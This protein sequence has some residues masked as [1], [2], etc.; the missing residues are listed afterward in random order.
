MTT[1][2]TSPKPQRAPAREPAPTTKASPGGGAR[3][4]LGGK[5]FAEQEALLA[6]AGA[7]EAPGA[8]KAARAAPTREAEDH[9]GGCC[10]IGREKWSEA[11]AKRAWDQTSAKSVSAVDVHAKGTKKDGKEGPDNYVKGRLSPE[12]I[13]SLEA[14][15]AAASA[16]GVHIHCSGPQST[17]RD[18]EGQWKMFHEK[19]HD[20]S[21]AARPGTSNHGT[22]RAID[23]ANSG[24]GWLQANAGHFGFVNYPNENWHFDHVTTPKVVEKYKNK[25][26]DKVKRKHSGGK[27][28]TLTDEERKALR[29]EY[30]DA[31]VVLALAW[32]EGKA[33]AP[34][35]WR[36]VQSKVGMRSASGVVDEATVEAVMDWQRGRGEKPDGKV[37]PKTLSALGV[38]TAKAGAQV[39]EPA[40]E[41]DARP[42]KDT[43]RDERRHGAPGRGERKSRGKGASGGW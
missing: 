18:L 30:H 19:G 37:G 41:P 24:L 39:S 4:Q 35:T 11:Q 31:E 40:R 17:L 8:E 22:G 20:T 6:P 21:L 14:M 32:N 16:D 1:T 26:E 27:T 7:E 13:P 9:S 29:T 12:L 34:A 23:F 28:A 10:A 36:A 15:L 33:Y 2:R 25:V 43:A 3:E 42:A 38:D 5:S